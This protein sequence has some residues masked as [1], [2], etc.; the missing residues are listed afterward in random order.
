MIQGIEQCFDVEVVSE[1]LFLRAEVEHLQ[2][3]SPGSLL[4]PLLFECLNP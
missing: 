1:A 4:R 3:S 2:Y